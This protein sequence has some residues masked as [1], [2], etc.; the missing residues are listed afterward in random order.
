MVE[1]AVTLVEIRYTKL[2]NP[3][4]VCIFLF[5][6]LKFIIMI[7]KILTLA[8]VL[9]LGLLAYN[10]F[11]GTAQEKEQA[12]EIRGK[13]KSIA[14]DLKNLVMSE[15]E[16]FDKGKFDDDIDKLSGIVSNIKDKAVS[17]GNEYS[18]KVEDLEKIKDQLSLKADEVEKTGTEADKEKLKEDL[19][20]LLTQFRKVSE[21]MAKE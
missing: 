17:L 11:F 3:A 7:R 8:V 18:D 4:F 10:S 1:R 19:N 12:A 13:M 21:D 2:K 5:S 20:N 6:K 9:A 14:V 16:K 15:K